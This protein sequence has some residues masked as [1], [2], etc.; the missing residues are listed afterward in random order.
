MLHGGA[1]ALAIGTIASLA[2]ART[3]YMVEV[4]DGSA[5]RSVAFLPFSSK[6][7]ALEAGRKLQFLIAECNRA[8]IARGVNW[9]RE[10][11]RIR[12]HRDTHSD[13]GQDQGRGQSPPSSV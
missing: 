12:D 5:D 7:A 2:F 1:I 6:E 8:G 13:S 11:G 3:D 4:L 10:L 9:Q